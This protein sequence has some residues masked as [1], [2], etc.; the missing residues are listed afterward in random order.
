MKSQKPPKTTKV[1]KRTIKKQDPRYNSKI[2]QR[3]SKYREA[4]RINQQQEE[5]IQQPQVGHILRTK[6]TM[7]VIG[8]HL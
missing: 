1:A 8:V 3:V 7:T 4:K 6:R 2:A 5:E